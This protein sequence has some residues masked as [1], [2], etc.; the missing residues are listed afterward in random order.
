MIVKVTSVDLRSRQ[1][2]SVDLDN[3]RTPS[4]LSSRSAGE[5]G[6]GGGAAASQYRDCRHAYFSGF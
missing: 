4:C 2:E 6:G 5:G 1:L 3:P